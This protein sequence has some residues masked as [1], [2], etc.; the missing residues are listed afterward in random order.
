MNR[1]LV[2]GASGKTGRH[3]VTSLVSRGST[4]RAAS[5]RPE[6]FDIEGAEPT[7][8]DWDDE[9][10]WG[11]A[12]TGVDGVYLVKPQS[13]E[14]VEI[15][16]RFLDSMKA[17]SADRLVL[18]SECAAQTRSD[19]ITEPWRPAAWSGRSCAR[20]GTWRTSSTTSSSAA[21]SAMTG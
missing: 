2:I 10:T 1:I 18:L 8:F 14:V 19:D 6:Q 16:A 12:L 13:A 11:P 5:R 7:R 3:V 20:A 15:V 21:W 4:V 17:A 9:S